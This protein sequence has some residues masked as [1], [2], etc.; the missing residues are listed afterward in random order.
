MLPNLFGWDLLGMNPMAQ[1]DPGA[2]SYAASNFRRG[3]SSL[4]SNMWPPNSTAHVPDQWVETANSCK[5]IQSTI[6]NIICVCCTHAQPCEERLDSLARGLPTCL[7]VLWCSA[8]TLPHLPDCV[9]GIHQLPGGLVQMANRFV[10]LRWKQPL[11]STPHKAQPTQS[12]N[13]D[14]QKRC[15]G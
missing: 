7:R 14:L 3:P 6:Q 1:C 8:P 11:S 5:R 13:P 15:N 4:C 12:A 9:S 2:S 10:P